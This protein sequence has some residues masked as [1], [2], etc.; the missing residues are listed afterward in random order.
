MSSRL[1]NSMA[2]AL[3]VGIMARADT[4]KKAA[5]QPGAPGPMTP[6][7]RMLVIRSLNAEM[8]F[9]HHLLPRGPKPIRVKNREIISPSESEIQMLAATNGPAA[10]QGDRAMIT[11]IE[12]KDDRIYFQINGGAKKKKRWYQHIEVQAGGMTTARPDDPRA[13]NPPGCIIVLEFDTKYVPEISGD[14]I[15]A[16]LEPVLDF[17]AKSAAEAYL[18]SVPPQVKEAIK[19]HQVLVGMNREMVGYAKGR[20]TRKIREQ[21]VNGKDYE[22][23]LYGAPPQEVEFVRFVG[24]EVVRLEIMTVDGQKIV[25]TT[26]EVDLQPV[27]AKEPEQPKP[28]APAQRPSL[29]L[30]GE[31]PEDPNKK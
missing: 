28:T 15:R 16:L 25:R 20:P 30:P 4:P 6:Q 31:E 18:E 8:V 29:R 10:K 2:V 12:I 19:N 13:E 7:T 3:L 17:H 11:N 1:F 26:K 22:E 23:W 14:E 24:D 5:N 9:A 21:D 27:A